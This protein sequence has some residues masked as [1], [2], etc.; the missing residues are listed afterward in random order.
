M[1]TGTV[2]VPLTLPRGLMLMVA[3]GIMTLVIQPFFRPLAQPTQVEATGTVDAAVCEAQAARVRRLEATASQLEAQILAAEAHRQQGG[4]N[5]SPLTAAGA[6]QV[7]A[8]AATAPSSP[9][10]QPWVWSALVMNALRPFDR[11]SGGITLRGLRLAEQKCKISTWCH[12][13]QVINGRLYVTDL[14]SIFFD[15]HYAMARVMPLLLAMK[16][17][18]VPNL[19]AVFSGTDYPIMELPRGKRQGPEVEAEAEAEVQAQAQIQ[20]QAQEQARAQA[21]A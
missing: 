19:D 18:A 2:H 15:R 4:A 5:G 7:V 14:R 13:A 3:G 21:L 20:A 6:V 1:G 8:P 12:R 17:F 10:H 16:H 9:P 11:L